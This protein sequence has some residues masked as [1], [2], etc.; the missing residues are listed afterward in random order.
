M[1]TV[2]EG[3]RRTRRDIYRVHTYRSDTYILCNNN[4]PAAAFGDGFSGN[5]D[6]SRSTVNNVYDVRVEDGG[7]QIILVDLFFESRALT[8]RAFRRFRKLFYQTAYNS[9]VVCSRARAR[10]ISKLPFT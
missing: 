9:L 7:P 6:K 10:P 5:P 1:A 4:T 2:T 8:R 3:A